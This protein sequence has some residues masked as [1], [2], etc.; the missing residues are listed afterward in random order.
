MKTIKRITAILIIACT[1]MAFTIQDS[2]N[3]VR[4]ETFYYYAYA[5]TGVNY[6]IYNKVWITPILKITI[7]SDTHYP[8][9]DTGIA[10]Q[11]KDYMEANYNINDVLGT[12]GVVYNADS[13]DEAKVTEYY[14][15]TLKRYKTNVKIYDFKYLPERN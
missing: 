11:M 14:R 15:S 12:E 9:T 8:M 7:N 1:T 13:F 5:T 6:E 10:L 4:T 2:A 3:N